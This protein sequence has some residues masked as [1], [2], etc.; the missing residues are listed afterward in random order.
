MENEN[1][2]F[3]KWRKPAFLAQLCCARVFYVNFDEKKHLFQTFVPTLLRSLRTTEFRC[4]RS[5]LK[6]K[7]PLL[8][9]IAVDSLVCWLGSHSEDIPKTKS[10]IF[11]ARIKSNFPVL[12]TS[13]ALNISIICFVFVFSFQRFYYYPPGSTPATV[14]LISI[15]Q[16]PKRKFP[17]D[18]ILFPVFP[19]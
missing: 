9:G 4:L 17:S 19:P 11:M 8:P 7:A 16:F 2:C 5:S 14:F 10:L 6:D 18:S 1:C 13:A 12:L 15:L 3:N